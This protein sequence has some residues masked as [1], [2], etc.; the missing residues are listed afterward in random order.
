MCGMEECK[1]KEIIAEEI[2]MGLNGN[3]D[4]EK[5]SEHSENPLQR[6]LLIDKEVREH[7]FHLLPISSLVVFKHN[8]EVK[9]G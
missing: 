5:S 9:V 2:K 3:T 8:L 7:V 6:M 4:N 1:K